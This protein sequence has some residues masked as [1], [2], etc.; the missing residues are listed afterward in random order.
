MRWSSLVVISVLFWSGIAGAQVSGTCFLEGQVDHSGTWVVCTSASVSAV[1]DSTQTDAGGAYALS[2]AVGLYEISY[3]HEGYL[4]LTL[5]DPVLVSSTPLVLDDVTLEAGQ[6]VEL[7]GTIGTLHL[8]TG[9]IARIVDFT[10]VAAGDSLTVDPGVRFLFSDYHAFIIDGYADFNG[11]ESDSIIFESEI[12]GAGANAWGEF[13]IRGADVRMQYC[14]I[15]QANRMTLD[16]QIGGPPAEIDHCRVEHTS[17]GINMSF[18]ATFHIRDSVFEDNLTS[19]VRVALTPGPYEDRFFERC[20]FRNTLYQNTSAVEV[21]DNSALRLVDCIIDADDPAQT[22]QYGIEIQSNASVEVTRCTISDCW[23]AGVKI[24]SGGPLL[25]DSCLITGNG[26]GV[27]AE[28]MASG[29][30]RNNTIVGNTLEGLWYGGPDGEVSHNILSGNGT[31]IHFESSGG[32]VIYND[33]ADNGVVFDG[34]FIP[35]YFGEAITTNANGDPADVYLNLFLSPEFSDAAGGDYSLMATSPCID[36]GDPARLDPDGTSV[37]LGAFYFDQSAS[38]VPV[39]S[40]PRTSLSCSPNPFNPATTIRFNIVRDGYV[41]LSVYNVRGQLVK[42][43]VD[44]MAAA[45][46]SSVTW[47]GTDRSGRSC[48]SGTYFLRLSNGG[49]VVTDKL[50]LAK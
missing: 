36:A 48:A 45:G 7:S 28:S 43:L 8:T 2:L 13:S 26:S 38:P 30:V 41:G 24:Q 11:T 14:V 23:S 20:L 15:R 12:P 47:D 40:T 22:H 9:T 31:G 49:E 21:F 34:D 1:S 29:V 6:I 19:A 25:V 27:N 32:S 44:G 16:N 17:S 50:L 3:R 33:I 39:P 5:P 4:P 10:R 18:G 35:A 42:T 37:D 46:S